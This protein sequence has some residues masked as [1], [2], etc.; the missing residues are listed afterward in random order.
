MAYRL[1][2]AR[3]PTSSSPTA[4]STK[5]G[6]LWCATRTRS[7]AHRRGDR[8][9]FAARKTEKS[10]DGQKIAGWFTEDFTPGRN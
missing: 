10:V 4:W 2:I 9:E 6:H 8:P 5:D 3:A 7:A 1:A